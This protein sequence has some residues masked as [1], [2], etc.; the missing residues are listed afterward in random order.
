MNNI[1]YDIISLYAYYLALGIAIWTGL[2]Y[3]EYL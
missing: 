3:V 1:A 2:D